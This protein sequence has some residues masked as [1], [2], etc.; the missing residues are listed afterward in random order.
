MKKKSKQNSSGAQVLII[1]MLVVFALLNIML[2]PQEAPCDVNVSRG[3]SWQKRRDTHLK[4]QAEVLRRVQLGEKVTEEV[5]LSYPLPS[6]DVFTDRKLFAR[7]FRL[8]SPTAGD[9]EPNAQG[10]YNSETAATAE[11]AAPEL[12]KFAAGQLRQCREFIN[13][14]TSPL[15][16]SGKSRAEAAASLGSALVLSLQNFGL[17]APELEHCY[18][19]NISVFRDEDDLANNGGRVKLRMGADYTD[20]Y[21]MKHLYR[22]GL[23]D[24]Q[25]PEHTA[26]GVQG[27]A[28]LTPSM[29][30][31]YRISHAIVKKVAQEVEKTLANASAE[32]REYATALMLHDYICHNCEYSG[33]AAAVNNQMLTTHTLLRKRASSAGYA[34]AYN[35]LLNMAGIKNA[36]VCGRIRYNGGSGDDDASIPHYWNMINIGGK[37][38]HV[39]ASANDPMPGAEAPI[40]HACFGMPYSLMESRYIF[41]GAYDDDQKLKL[42]PE[43]DDSFWYFSHKK[44]TA[45]SAQELAAALVKRAIAGKLENEYLYTGGKLSQEELNEAISQYM[46]QEK[47]RF[48]ENYTLNMDSQPLRLEGVP[49]ASIIHTIFVSPSKD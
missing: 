32:E 46:V 35:L 10:Q 8:L 16:G 34:R 37:W 7:Q 47:L 41:N 3:D 42:E 33:A 5:S 26:Y 15:P 22:Q 1:I 13:Y 28:Q 20:L 11:A 29:Y 43:T 21:L 49:A 27:A 2:M 30:A 9:K 19:S 25:D 40:S 24:N 48:A 18:I 36:Y 45:A 31:A 39:D 44:L 17:Q 4:Q 6:L 23:R 38:F 14:N 12:K